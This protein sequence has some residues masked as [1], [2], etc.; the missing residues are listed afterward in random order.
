[1]R[2]RALAR[3]ATGHAA[4][5]I[6]CGPLTLD[7]ATGVFELNGLPLKLT[8]LEWRVLQGL[9]MRK[10]AVFDRIALMESVYEGDA[11]A[12]SNS[13]EVIVGRLRRKIGHDLIETVRGRGYRLM[14]GA[15]R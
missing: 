12:D 1:M 11:G 8:A 14:C 13:L 10:D 15:S 2:L 5:S 9:M 3:R 6:S 4:P 7:T